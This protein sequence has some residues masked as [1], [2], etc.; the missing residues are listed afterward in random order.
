MGFPSGSLG[1][2][3][4]WA[5]GPPKTMKLVAQASSLCLDTRGRVSY[6]FR[7]ENFSKKLRICE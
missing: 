6:T 5:S 7:A 2:S 3:H 4:S 1:T